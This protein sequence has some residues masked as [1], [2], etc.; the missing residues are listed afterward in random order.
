MH[1][2]VCMQKRKEAMLLANDEKVKALRQL[3]FK[4][5][6]SHS[7]IHHLSSLIPNIPFHIPFSSSQQLH[8]QLMSDQTSNIFPLLSNAPLIASQLSFASPNS[9]L[10][11]GIK[12]IGFG[13][14]A[15][16]LLIPLFITIT[17][18]LFHACRT[19]IPAMEEPG[20]SAMG[21]T[22]SLAPI[23]RVRSVSGKS[24]FISSISRTTGSV[25]GWVWWGH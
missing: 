20:S 13:T 22:V 15:Y 14:S 2:V 7:S 8:L 12:N 19:G 17:C 21:F 3:Q 23:T 18:L 4:C 24:S 16:P 9:I 1:A 11:P 5:P 6:P 25:S 10:V